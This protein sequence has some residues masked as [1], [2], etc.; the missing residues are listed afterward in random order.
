MSRSTMSGSQP[1]EMDH[2]ALRRRDH[3]NWGLVD[4][5][6]TEFKDTSESVFS[7]NVQ[8]FDNSL[9]PVD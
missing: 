3:K 9:K 6:M 7:D 8:E 5:I 1:K 2:L 4:H